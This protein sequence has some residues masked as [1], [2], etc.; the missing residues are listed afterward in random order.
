MNRTLK[1]L[2]FTL[3]G[4]VA[5]VAVVV[6]VVLATFDPNAWKQVAVDRVQQQYGRTL[7]IPGA[8]KLSFFPRIGVHTGEVSLSE[9]GNS[10][11]FASLKSA[12]VSLALLP[13][14]S[15][16][17]EVAKVVV[18]GLSVR[19]ERFADGRTSIDDLLGKPAAAPAP[20]ASAAAPGQPLALDIGGLALRDATLVFDDRQGRRRVEL[21][22]AGVELGRVQPGRPTDF[23]FQGRL[24]VDAPATDVQLSL[25]TVLQIDE[26]A[27]RLR[28]D[29]L[30]AAVEGALAGLA[31]AKATL[32][33]NVDLDSA[34]AALKVNGLELGFDS[35]APALQAKVVV[36]ALEGDAQGLRLP[37]LNASAT[38]PNPKGGTVALKA[39]G[40]ATLRLG[41]KPGLD[42]QLAGTLDESRFDAKLSMPSLSPA[43]YRFDVGMD[44]LGLDRY[45]KAETAAAPAAAAS[46]PEA[47]LDLSALQG[48]DAAGSLR[49]G[50]LQVMN[51]KLQ[52]L[53]TELR[54]AGGQLALNPLALELYQGRANGSLALAGAAT[55]HVALKQTLADVS[56]GPLLHDLLGK[57][58]IEGRGSV[59]LDVQAQGR[60]VTALKKALAGSARAELRDG[61]VKGFNIG[62]AIRDA[63]A[64][65]KGEGGT[66]TPSQSTDFSELTASFRIANGVAHNDDLQA[67]SPLLRV[68]G[69][70]DIDLGESRLDYVVKAT[71][72]DSLK[73][74]GGAELDALRG[75]TVPV[76]LFGPF[77]AIGWKVDFG[78]MVSG[79]TKQK[80]EAAKDKVEEKAKEKA[81]EKLKSLF[82]R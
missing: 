14:L 35:R 44:K 17:V 58:P 30:D 60:T 67:K 43:A 24:K 12:Q 52:N 51:L 28:L 76:K 68:G 5:L 66:G 33:G 79:A 11:P 77:S 80:V 50:T 65:L 25:K 54:A 13:L 32:R 78:A 59:A 34:S 46:A 82:G 69:A 74:Q 70:G 40:K 42:A 55:P 26:A 15:R 47:P 4:L 71:V 27:H 3:L 8:L 21:A 29:K 45:R 56:L 2:L 81:K 64:K 10:K 36:P 57:A 38:L 53:K 6:A 41:A 61:A 73:G 7:A 72:V 18:E 20:A 37:A 23:V 39:D 62:Q 9:A 1:I 75:Q 16:R 22:Q 48:L 49:V 63:K 31:G 19:V